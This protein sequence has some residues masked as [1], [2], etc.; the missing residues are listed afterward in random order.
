MA[1]NYIQ[2]GD[3]LTLPAPSGGVVSGGGYKIGVMFGVAMATAAETVDVAFARTGVFEL[4]KVSA[5]AWT[6]GAA[7]YWDDDAG[8]GAVATTATTAGNLLI[9]FA[10][11]DAVNPTATG[12]VCLTGAAPAAVTS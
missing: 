4:P 3:V 1:T 7:I 9:G 5:Q 8:G 10:A 6:A 11:A 2:P 12:M